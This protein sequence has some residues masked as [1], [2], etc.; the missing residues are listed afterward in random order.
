[1]KL[2]KHFRESARNALR[3]KWGIA[4]IASVIASMLGGNLFDVDFNITYKEES[5]DL[6]TVG[7]EFL[8]QIYA[9]LLVSLPYILLTMF[10][11]LVIGSTV[12]VGHARLYLDIIDGYPT[13]IG[14]LF[15]Y[16]RRW[17][18]AVITELL[19]A[20]IIFLGII[21]FLVPGIIAAYSLSMT[22]Y[23]IAENDGIKVIDAMK[24]SHRIMRGKR[25][26]LFCLHVSFIG[27]ILLSVLTFGIGFLWVNPYINAACTD[28]YRSITDSYRI[29]YL[30]VDEPDEA[31]EESS[32]GDWYYGE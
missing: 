15:S 8:E 3:G 13:S 5:E 32:D 25:F 10:I 29:P 23:I 17:G 24:E 4:V 9:V 6:T 16:F 21:L 18:T 1:M 26:R 12:K 2:A 11:A 31:S 22:P 28:F 20:V 27:W 14:T 7:P 30:R 19:K